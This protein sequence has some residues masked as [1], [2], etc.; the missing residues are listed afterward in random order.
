MCVHVHS[1]CTKLECCQAGRQWMCAHN[2]IRQLLGLLEADNHEFVRALHIT[3]PTATLMNLPLIAYR[4]ASIA[5]SDMC[6]SASHHHFTC[7]LVRWQP[8]SCIC[9]RNHDQYTTPSCFALEDTKQT[10]NSHGGHPS[11]I[12]SSYPGML[13]PLQSTS[14]CSNT[15]HGGKQSTG[16]LSVTTD[17]AQ[18]QL[19]RK[20][21]PPYRPLKTSR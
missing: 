3:C 8:G 12:L 4:E 13:Q 9:C 15:C 16:R 1:T 6:N 21:T 2:I 7:P 18:P 19:T 14:R 10:W 20:V 5:N 17:A 11:A